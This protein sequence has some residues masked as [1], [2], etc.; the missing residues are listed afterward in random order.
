[1]LQ[2]VHQDLTANFFGSSLVYTK[3]EMS[4]QNLL[5]GNRIE[6]MTN[7]SFRGEDVGQLGF[8]LVGL[9]VLRQVVFADLQLFQEL[10]G[11]SK[12]SGPF[13]SQV[14]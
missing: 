8:H 12:V 13:P 2:I 6:S 11:S 14:P 5:C 7:L 9:A 4:S 1:M 10:P 3:V